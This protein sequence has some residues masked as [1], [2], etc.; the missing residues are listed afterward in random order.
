VIVVSKKLIILIL[1]GIHLLSNSIFAGEFSVKPVYDTTG[2]SDKNKTNESLFI[3]MKILYEDM[4]LPE[5]PNKINIV[6]LTRYA[7]S[8]PSSKIPYILDIEAWKIGPTV[9]DSVA[10]SN[11][12]KYITV[13]KTMKTARPDLQFGFFGVLPVMDVI[14]PRVALRAELEQWHHANLRVKRIANYVDVVCPSPYTFYNDLNLWKN[15]TLFLMREAK[16]Y[17][18]PVLPFLWPEF[19]DC[20][21]FK[22]QFLPVSFWEE[23]L[24]FAY[25]HG[26]GVCIWGGR[27]L[28]THEPR[29]WDE[30]AGWWSVTK[31]LILKDREEGM[32]NKKNQTN[33]EGESQGGYYKPMLWSK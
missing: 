27:N 6:F 29:V 11:I 2:Y 3:P 16:M 10:N 20:T 7:Q 4:L 8:L 1:Y 31:R 32:R 30:K 18:K 19:M 25:N 28:V 17:G 14:R 23:E 24:M 13:I 9:S 21:P 5:G 15:F 22:G 26:D 12:D 33:G